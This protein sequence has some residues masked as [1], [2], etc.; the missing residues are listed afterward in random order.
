MGV[1]WRQAS[2]EGAVSKRCLN[3]PSRQQVPTGT[4]LQGP[5]TEQHWPGPPTFQ[6]ERWHTSR[7]EQA[8]NEN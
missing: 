1:G 6:Q 2:V 3:C 4:R 7:W 8:R 5:S